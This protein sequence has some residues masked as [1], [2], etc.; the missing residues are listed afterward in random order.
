MKLRLVYGRSGSGKSYLCEQEIKEQLKK[1][2]SE[3]LILL[4]PE[5]FTLQ[6]EKS[7]IKATG[8]EGIMRAEVLS[9]GRM[10]YRI[11][12][13]VGGIAQS[14]IQ[15][16]GKCM[17]LYQVMDS[18]KDELS[19]FAKAANQQG[20][21]DTLVDTFAE[22][23]RYH[24]TPERLKKA[25]DKVKDN[26]FLQEKIQDISV[27]YQNFEQT[28]QGRYIDAEDDLTLL[29]DKLPRSEQ[30]DHAHI[31]ID[32]FSGFTP[33][34]YSVIEQLIKKV[35]RVTVCLCSDCLIDEQGIDST[36]VFAPTKWAAKKLLDI[37]VGIGA[38]IEK[39]V[40]MSTRPIYR[41]W[42][43][44]ELAHLEKYFFSFPHTSYTKPTEKIG[45]F[46]AVNLYSEVEDTARDIVRLCREEKLRYR[47]LGVITR[48]LAAYEELITAIFRQYDIPFFIDTKKEVKSHPLVLL[49][50]SALDIFVYHWSYAAVFRYLKTGLTDILREEI[51]I[52]E[53]YV[54]ETGIRGVT[55]WTKKETWNAYVNPRIQQE[56]SEYQ[57]EQMAKINE[58]RQKIITPLTQF[59]ESTKG[60]KTIL[61]MC[62]AVHTFLCELGVPERIEKKVESFRQM[63]ELNL[64]NQ[65][66]QIWHLLMDVLNQ[67]VDTMGEQRITMKQYKTFF[68]IGLEQ[69][70]LGLIPPAL[71]QVFVGSVERSRNQGLKTLYV[72]GVNDG[73]FPAVNNEEGILSDADRHYL[74]QEGLE[75]APDTRAQAFEEQF[76]IYKT[77]TSVNGYLRLS[78]PIADLEGRALRP[79]VIIAR[80]KKIFANIKERSNIVIDKSDEAQYEMI[81]TPQPTFNQM[82]MQM[83][84]RI[85]GQEVNPVWWGVYGWF[86]S[87]DDWKHKCQMAL[88]GI[89]YTNEVKAVPSK[90]IKKLYGS[91]IYTSISRMEQ[92][93]S[94]PFSHYV[95]YGLKAKER[96]TFTLRA[97]D[98]GS[99]MHDVLEMFFKC[100]KAKE[101]SWEEITKEWCVQTVSEIVDQMLTDMSHQIL[102]SS[103]RYHYIAGRLKR[104]LARAVWVITVHIQKSGFEPIGHEMAFGDSGDF[105]PIDIMLST[106]E[107]IKLVGRIDRVD[108]LKTEEGSY[109]RII[110][111][112]SG[113]RS[114]ALSDVYYGLQIQLI[115]YLDALWEQGGA[116][117]PPPILPGGMLYFKMDD[118]IVK[119]DI[120]ATEQEIEQQIMKQLKMKG[121]LL[122]DVK[123]VKEMDHDIAG[124]SMIIPARLNKGDVLGKTSSVATEKQFELLRGHVKRLLA[125]LGE[126]MLRGDVAIRPYKKGQHTSCTYCEYSAVCQFEPM[127]HKEGYRILNDLKEEQVWK[128]IESQGTVLQAGNRKFCPSSKK[129][130][131]F[132]SV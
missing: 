86:C 3:R 5:Q 43:N 114:F 56:P 51:D 91:P 78:Y 88:S 120:R 37:A 47:Q 126:E 58:I 113:N 74:K 62:T 24:V 73:V 68:S 39:P 76:L 19:V 49:I 95:K 72:L 64:A 2:G 23:K 90:K 31:W 75:L 84:H 108:A 131:G 99:F 100:V 67:M 116:Q 17:L 21:V 124:E 122:A 115:T 79:S 82:V 98:L 28:L 105:A 97:P 46:S 112:K 1:E 89:F 54:L 27:I 80:M 109:L 10:A 60:K 103:K 4:V 132:R 85:E 26:A 117:L 70:Q 14:H 44:E 87:Q 15:R 69:C 53:N 63:G 101:I 111:Y 61:D 42:D 29:A 13:E 128:M 33:Q 65:Y 12:N 48:D 71:D 66:E 34:E 83:H 123:L 32:A 22:F 118:P 20:F 35:S 25:K 36:E 81:S 59:Y 30:F 96:K 55:K 57:K 119:G 11:F 92:F 121:L 18:L 6:A 102:N 7:L 40:A 77:L 41:F 107:K 104:I 50:L 45:M 16:A 106:G 9:F 94:C 38:H 110:D 125:Q 129:G 52:I 8:K 127:L 93:A 130:Q